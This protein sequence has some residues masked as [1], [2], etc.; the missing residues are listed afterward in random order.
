LEWSVAKTTG[1]PELAEPADGIHGTLRSIQDRSAFL[2]GYGTAEDA[3][4]GRP[5]AGTSL[6]GLVGGGLTLVLATGIAWLVRKKRSAAAPA[7]GD[8]NARALS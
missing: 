1:S 7:H 6:A 4:W 8:G 3:D 2:P 5:S